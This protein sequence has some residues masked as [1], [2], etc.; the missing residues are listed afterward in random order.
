MRITR[1]LCKENDKY[2]FDEQI[3]SELLL[4]NNLTE[5]GWIADLFFIIY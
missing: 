3:N 4:I 5:S 2:L 1:I